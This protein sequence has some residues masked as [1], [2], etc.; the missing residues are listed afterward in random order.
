MYLYRRRVENDLY[1]LRC[2]T[3]AGV[4]MQSTPIPRTQS[5]QRHRENTTT[6]TRKGVPKGVVNGFKPPPSQ[7]KW[8]APKILMISLGILT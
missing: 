3:A 2:I 4:E 5:A 1:R 8:L 6:L 7:K